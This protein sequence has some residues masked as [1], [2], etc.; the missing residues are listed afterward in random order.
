MIAV[1]PNVGD[2][3][4]LNLHGI[5][6]SRYLLCARLRIT[7]CLRNGE[8]LEQL[9]DHQLLRVTVLHGVGSNK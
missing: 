3:T 5:E 6:R 1:N 4:T 9:R 2:L 8:I 7:H